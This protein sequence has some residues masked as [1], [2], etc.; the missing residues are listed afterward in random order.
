MALEIEPAGLHEAERLGDAVGELLVMVRLR[1]VLDE[2]EHPLPHIGEIGVAALGERAQQ[3]ER[4]GGVAKRL[5]LPLRDRA[6]RAS[7]VNSTPLMMSPR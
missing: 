3:I 2:A 5:D 1:R 6:A 7:S 4:R